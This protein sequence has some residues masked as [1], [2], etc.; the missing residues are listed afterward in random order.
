MLTRIIVA[1]ISQCIQILN[2]FTPKT[3]IISILVNYTLI[4]KKKKL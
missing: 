3:N 4:F 2:L 1:I